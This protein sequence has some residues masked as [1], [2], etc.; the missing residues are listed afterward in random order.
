M[1]IIHATLGDPVEGREGEYN[2]ILEETAEQILAMTMPVLIVVVGV[3][4]T[5]SFY[6][7][8]EGLGQTSRT[9]GYGKRL[10]VNDNCAVAVIDVNNN[11]VTGAIAFAAS[12]P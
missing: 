7:Y 1:E 3:N 4:Q 6:E 12:Q 11:Q 9:I 2:L 5:A 8:A 10:L